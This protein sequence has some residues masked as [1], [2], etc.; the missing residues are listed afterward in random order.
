VAIIALSQSDNQV[1][2]E[3]TGRMAGSLFALCGQGTNPG[4]LR[5]PDPWFAFTGQRKDA[6]QARYRSWISVAA[7]CVIGTAISMLPVPQQISAT[8]IL[9]PQ[10]KQIYYAPTDAVVVKVLVED[11]QTIQL[12]QPLLELSDWKLARELERLEGEQLSI[13]TS[14]EQLEDDRLRRGQTTLESEQTDG[15]AEQLK[16]SIANNAKQLEL[17][18]QQRQELTIVA[19]QS[20]KIS[21]WDVRNRLLNRPVSAGD[22]LLSVYSPDDDW[23]LQV[24]IPEHRLGLVSQ[25][26]EQSEGERA[27]AGGVRTR[28]V[29]T[30]HPDQVIEGRLTSLASQAMRQSSGTNVVLATGRVTADQ[31]PSSK[32]GAIARAT[33]DCGHVPAIWLL[34]RDAYW[35]IQSRLKLLW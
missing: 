22:Q 3:E 30:S 18:K 35:A 19:K 32:D 34:L 15:K 11:E 2:T 14:I 4:W 31:L 20:G 13:Q 29:L 25:V 10:S 9:A 27:V 1:Q 28:F 24:S 7:L 16:A 17:L 21:S 6:A 8:A 23:Q 33:I 12:G 5:L 26:L